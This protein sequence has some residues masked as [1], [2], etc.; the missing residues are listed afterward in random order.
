MI[1]YT[2]IKGGDAWE[3]FCRD[4]LVAM[5]LVVDTPPGRG[6][7]GGRDLIVTEQLKGHLA[8]RPFV[9]LVSCKHY[10]VSG[11]AIGTEIEQNIT[12]RMQHHGAAG[13]LGFYSTLASAALIDRLKDLRDQRKIAA[14][15]IFDGASIE[16]RFFGTGMSNVLLQHLPK[17]HTELR[18]IHPLFG[19]YEPLKCEVC[20]QDLLKLSLQRRFGSVIIFGS[21]GDTIQ[22]IHFACKGECDRKITS[23][24]TNADMPNTWD[25]LE[26]YCNPLIFLRRITGYIAEMRNNPASY[27]DRA[28]EKMVS[29]YLAVSQLTLRQASQ[30]DRDRFSSAFQVEELGV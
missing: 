26:D 21:R 20:Q 15:E 19:T 7:D 24:L 8:S 4:Y 9:W 6:P 16:N 28:H 17:S 25:D 23:R 13:F 29:L 3:A 18:P 11:A 1:D 12:D 5:G 2:E 14:F 27:S 22:D 10:A 30:E